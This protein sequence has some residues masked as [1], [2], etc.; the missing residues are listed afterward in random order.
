MKKIFNEIIKPLLLAIFCGFILGRYYFKIYH[1][2]LHNELVSEKIYLVQNGE[3]DSISEL[4]F[5][6][7]YDKYVYYEDDN[8]YKSIIGITSK[9]DN[10][11]KIKNLVSDSIVSEYYIPYG[12]ID[13]KQIVYDNELEKTNDIKEIRLIVDNILNLYKSDEGIKLISID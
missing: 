4:R 12:S 3:Y 5:N 7:N 2:Y 10:A 6:N 11:V 9:Y 1:D 8:K 13:S